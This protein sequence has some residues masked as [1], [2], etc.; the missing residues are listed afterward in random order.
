MV[1]VNHEL[2]RR[3]RLELGWT[4]E[5]LAEEAVL[6]GRTIRRIEKG[7]SLTRL[8]SAIAIAQALKIELGTLAALGDGDGQN[9]NESQSDRLDLTAVL[10]AAED[11][12]QRE[13]LNPSEWGFREALYVLSLFLTRSLVLDGK[14]LGEKGDVD[15]V[16]A[17]FKAADG[18]IQTTLSGAGEWDAEEATS[19]LSLLLIRYGTA[20]SRR[21]TNAVEAGVNFIQAACDE[22]KRSLPHYVAPK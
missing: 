11:T 12:V 21:S 16:V 5:R 10:A 17:A 15:R 22:A 2:M 9:R 8:K 4:P 19:V 14:P 13:L 7:G 6:D 3:R 1:R 20:F 18:A